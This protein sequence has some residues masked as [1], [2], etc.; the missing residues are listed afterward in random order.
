MGTI[1][2]TGMEAIL[3]LCVILLMVG[4]FI[5]NYKNKQKIDDLEDKIQMMCR[6]MKDIADGDAEV[7]N[8]SQGVT[9]KVKEGR[10]EAKSN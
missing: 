4:S 3:I 2:L 10:N 7:I 8:T 5:D 1:E 9:V 6:V